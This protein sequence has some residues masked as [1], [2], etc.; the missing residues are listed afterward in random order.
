MLCAGELGAGAGEPLER[1]LGAAA[2]S[3]A[4]R[5]RAPASSGPSVLWPGAERRHRSRATS[6]AGDWPFV[7]Q[8]IG[9]HS[10][11]VATCAPAQ[12][13]RGDALEQRSGLRD[14]PGCGA[15]GALAGHP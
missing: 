13:H 11:R 2:W 4:E 14:R 12:H 15:R 5:P 8:L 9:E 3:T 1:G 10:R 6:G 7:D